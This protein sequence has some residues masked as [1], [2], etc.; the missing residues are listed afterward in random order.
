[1]TSS[2]DGDEIRK[3]SQLTKELDKVINRITVF[4]ALYQSKKPFFLLKQGNRDKKLQRQTSQNSNGL[5]K[6]A[7]LKRQNLVTEI[8]SGLTS[9]VPSSLH[10][11]QN[12][13]LGSRQVSQKN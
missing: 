9:V 11:N 13:R 4:K 7:T 5:D 3:S 10:T 6:Q 8:P 12:S 2:E 1:M